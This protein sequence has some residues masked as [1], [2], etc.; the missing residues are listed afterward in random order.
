MS[1]PGI[2]QLPGAKMLVSSL[3]QPGYPPSNEASADPWLCVTRFLW[4]CPFGELFCNPN[5]ITCAIYLSTKYSSEANVF[6]L[7]LYVIENTRNIK[8]QLKS[9]GNNH[10]TAQK[11]P[12][13][14]IDVVI[15]S[16]H[17]G[18]VGQ[19]CVNFNLAVILHPFFR[20]AVGY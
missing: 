9:G 18:S 10:E 1:A 13:K 5:E 12:R 6:A 8:K 11:K 15:F 19:S 17:P 14:S 4:L 3:R 7:F 20:I 16:I 2:P